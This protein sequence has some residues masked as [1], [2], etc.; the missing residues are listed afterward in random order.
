VV[1]G[2]DDS[3]HKRSLGGG[4]GLSVGSSEAVPRAASAA[5]SWPAVRG[6]GGAAGVGGG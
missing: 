3:S 4:E 2:S 5:G 6:V 1:D